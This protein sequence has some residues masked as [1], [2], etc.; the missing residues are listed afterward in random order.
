MSGNVSDGILTET[1]VSLILFSGN[2]M[3]E[4][5]SRKIFKKIIIRTKEFKRKEKEPNSFFD[6]NVKTKI[7]HTAKAIVVDKYL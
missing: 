7:Q 6:L 1:S 3:E 4:I 2:F 5:V